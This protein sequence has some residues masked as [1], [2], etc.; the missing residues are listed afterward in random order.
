MIPFVTGKLNSSLGCYGC[1]ESTDALD[2]EDL[3]G[4]PYPNMEK[5]TLNLQELAAKPT[6][7]V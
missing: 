6:K 2:E 3:I 4:I 7:K 5:I 1:R